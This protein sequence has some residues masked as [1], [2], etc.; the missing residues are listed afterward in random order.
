MS[1]QY[2][3]G[4]AVDAKHD[5]AR[6]RLLKHFASFAICFSTRLACYGGMPQSS[7]NDACLWL[8]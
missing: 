8:A 5:G 2:V 4:R 3:R 1:A 6:Q 7:L